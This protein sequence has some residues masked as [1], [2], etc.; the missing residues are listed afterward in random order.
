MRN[1]FRIRPGCSRLSLVVLWTVVPLASNCY[2]ED[3]EAYI[4]RASCASATCHGGISGRGPAWNSSLRTWEATDTHHAAAGIVLLSDQSKQMVAALVG[5]TFN[6]TTYRATLIE[7]CASC[8]SPNLIDRQSPAMSSEVDWRREISDGVSCE[9]CHGPAAKWLELHTLQVSDDRVSTLGSGRLPTKPWLERTDNC[10]RC[11]LGSRPAGSVV[12]DMNH[13]LIAAGHPALRFDMSLYHSILPA[14]WAVEPKQRIIMEPHQSDL[15]PRF[16]AA[17]V[18]E[19][20]TPQQHHLSRLRTL[21]AAAKLSLDRIEASRHGL[22]PRPEFAEYNCLACHQNLELSTVDAVRVEQ[23]LTWNAMITQ[24]TLLDSPVWIADREGLPKW[25]ET[26]ES[27]LIAL[28]SAAEDCLVET[29]VTPVASLAALRAAG[30]YQITIENNLDYDLAASW[31]W[32]NRL[33]LRNVSV[34]MPSSDS[35]ESQV[36][37]LE[38]SAIA[39]LNRVLDAFA[40]GLNSP[41]FF[42]VDP[43]AYD[44]KAGFPDWDTQTERRP[45]EL[46]PASPLIHLRDTYRSQLI[47]AFS[48]PGNLRTNGVQP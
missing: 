30:D 2:P 16:R 6:E 42:A 15:E 19:F 35:R 26:L 32:T 43:L 31:W 44:S 36:R 27:K 46:V 13:D 8:H 45:T 47:E 11:H 12:R 4:G 28:V 10:L 14:H 23:K 39:E 25:E 41:V 18:F 1:W 24:H 17:V 5:S 9:A 40:R 20:P 33:M 48:A 38:K 37:H 3:S 7:R 22:A 34:T 29:Q 21:V